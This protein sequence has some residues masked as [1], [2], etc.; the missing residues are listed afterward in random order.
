MSGKRGLTYFNKSPSYLVE[1]EDSAKGKVEV[2]GILTK[3]ALVLIEG[4]QT[5]SN[6]RKHVFTPERLA[7]IA[8]KTNN[9]LNSGNR[10]PI[11]QDHRK[12]QNSVIG[13]VTGEFFLKEITEKDLYN[14]KL[15]DLVGKVG[16]FATEVAIR[17]KKAIEQA[18][19][20]LLSTI[21]AGL[22]LATEEI[23][24]ISAVPLPA[25]RGCA[26]FSKYKKGNAKFALTLADAESEATDLAELKEALDS[27][28]DK[29][30]DVIISIS[31]A[32]ED[33]LGDV[34][35]KELQYQAI[36]DYAERIVDL[37][38]LNAPDEAELLQ[39]QLGEG[40]AQPV[41]NNQ[42]GR[43]PV[44]P[45]RSYNNNE[46]LAAFS[47]SDMEKI[48]GANAE[49]LFNPRFYFGNKPEPEKPGLLRRGLNMAGSAAKVGAIGLGGAAAL[50]YGGAGLARSG[51]QLMKGRTI[52]KAF[53]SGVAQARTTLGRDISRAAG[54]ANK[55]PGNPTG[56]VKTRIGQTDRFGRKLQGVRLGKPRLTI[57]P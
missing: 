11:I 9:Y 23:R 19:E 13:D 51:G 15:K 46:I 21:S 36:S 40:V 20:G 27:V 18:R 8:Q 54:L 42:Y 5:D 1:T 24:E 35:P 25:I 30:W 4:E 38:G 52:R 53:R 47:M 6:Q 50:R 43:M 39:Q 28:T 34:N 55:L 17:S 10:L 7:L 31:E 37:L 14:P 33:E 44:A 48:V 56:F 12:E 57:T 32:S 41:M 2:D 49:F 16:L 22:N 29:F 45:T 3:K 26:M